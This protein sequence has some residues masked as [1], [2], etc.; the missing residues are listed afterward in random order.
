MSDGKMYNPYSS[1]IM[2]KSKEYELVKTEDGEYLPKV[3]SEKMIAERYLTSVHQQTDRKEVLDY[4]YK[5]NLK[6]LSNLKKILINMLML[7]RR[8]SPIVLEQ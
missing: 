6:N 8:K 2:P 3:I 7:R 1:Y 5:N 4:V